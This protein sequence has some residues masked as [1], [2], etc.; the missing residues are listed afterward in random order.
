M[1]WR[2]IPIFWVLF[3]VIFLMAGFFIFS[4]ESTF[5][6]LSARIDR[7]IQKN[8]ITQPIVLMAVGD[9]MLDRGVKY[10]VDKY[11]NGD[12]N[13]VFNG[14]KDYL[15]KADILFGNLEGPISNRG[16]RVGSIYSFRFS[17]TSTLALKEAGFDILSIANNHMFDYQAIALGDT[18]ANLQKSGIDYVGAGN[19]ETEA[20]SLKVK[21][22]QGVKFGF[23]AFEN[24]GHESW[25]AGGPAQSPAGNEAGGDKTGMAW[26]GW[27]DFDEVKETIAQ[28]KQQVDILVVS[29]HAGVEYQTLPDDF[30]IAFDK[31]AID[32]GADLVVGHHPH[33]IEPLEKH[34]NGWI[35]YSLGNFIFDQYFSPQTMEGGLL[36]VEIVDKKISNVILE[37]VKLNKYYQPILL[38]TKL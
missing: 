32:S 31:M 9:I 29:L 24:L 6:V 11:G 5:S 20:F 34:N 4:K 33:V 23:L 30:Q 35:I 21:E 18:M 37:K 28:S 19:N 36:K 27:G 1:Q 17:P 7:P 2:Y 12:F 25:K 10:M 16:V 14:I 8:Q 15:N 38:S 3:A 22:I 26:V 13:F